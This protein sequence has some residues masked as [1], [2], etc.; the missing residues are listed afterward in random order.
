MALV[1]TKA[2]PPASVTRRPPRLPFAFNVP[3]AALTYCPGLRF[4]RIHPV[5]AGCQ[6]MLL[7]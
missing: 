7:P 1:I 3:D 6:A 5:D 4:A 2:L